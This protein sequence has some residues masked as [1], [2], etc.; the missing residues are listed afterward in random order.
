MDEAEET[1]ERTTPVRE[2]RNLVMAEQGK[3]E[4]NLEVLNLTLKNRKGSDTSHGLFVL[5]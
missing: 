4:K 3:F 5:L 2:K 1:R